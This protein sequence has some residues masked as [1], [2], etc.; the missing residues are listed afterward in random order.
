VAETKK[1]MGLFQSAQR[2]EKN[3]GGHPDSGCSIALQSIF[4]SVRKDQFS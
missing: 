3:T 4:I 1:I 2:F